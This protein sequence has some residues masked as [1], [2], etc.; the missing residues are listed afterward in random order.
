MTKTYTCIVCPMSCRITVEEQDGKLSVSGNTCKRGYKYA[1]N[2][3][4]S[5][6]RMVTS[7]VKVENGVLR[8]LPV[9]SDSE[10]LKEK[11]KECLKVIYE[12]SISA[13]IKYGDV[14]VENICGTGVN[15]IASRDIASV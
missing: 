10:I 7:T 9:V 13:P 4:T 3:H 2:E 6:K 12:V 5:P 14:I 1:L 15:I 8:R 11:I